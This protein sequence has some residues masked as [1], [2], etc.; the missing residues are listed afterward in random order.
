MHYLDLTNTQQRMG[1]F[2]ASLWLLHNPH[3]LFPAVISENQMFVCK[4]SLQQKGRPSLHSNW[5]KL[6]GNTK[7]NPKSRQAHFTDWSPKMEKGKSMN[8]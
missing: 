6:G 2:T 5:L 8:K 7:I 3:V 1:E 4:V